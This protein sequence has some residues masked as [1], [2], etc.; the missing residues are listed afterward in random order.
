MWKGVPFLQTKK[1]E[2]LKTK[3][4]KQT[5][6]KKKKKK[7]QKKKEKKTDEKERGLS[8]DPRTRLR[9]RV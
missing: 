6:A 2:N 4:T 5:K 9:F 1:P 3:N 7:R 8:Q